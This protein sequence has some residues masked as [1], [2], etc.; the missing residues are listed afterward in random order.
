MPRRRR[1]T[2][3][4]TRRRAPCGGKGAGRRDSVCPAPVAR[5]GHHILCLSAWSPATR[6]ARQ[7]RFGKGRHPL[8]AGTVTGATGAGRSRADPSRRR[9]AGTTWWA[10]CRIKEATLRVPCPKRPERVIAEYAQSRS[11]HLG[12]SDDCLLGCRLRGGAAG[13]RLRPFW[14]GGARDVR[15]PLTGPAGKAL[16]PARPGQRKAGAGAP[17]KVALPRGDRAGRE[18]DA[19]KWPPAHHAAG[20]GVPAVTDRTGRGARSQRPW[21]ADPRFWAGTGLVLLALM[22]MVLALLRGIWPL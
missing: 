13:R 22:A 21:P 20:L 6:V 8:A 5:R 19:A 4:P 11:R 14:A 3:G 7:A 1:P 15:G 10:A 2:A 16:S 17:A 12:C 9:A 18:E